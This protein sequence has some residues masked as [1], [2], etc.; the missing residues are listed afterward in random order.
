MY[1]Y[2]ELSKLSREKK[3]YHDFYF[4]IRAVMRLDE[5]LKS[6]CTSSNQIS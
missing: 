3:E 4:L 2:V 1:F 6:E 5:M